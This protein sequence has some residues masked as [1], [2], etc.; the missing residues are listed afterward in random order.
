MKCPNSYCIYISYIGDSF[1]DCPFGEDEFQSNNIVGIAT[2]SYTLQ[3]TCIDQ[4]AYFVVSKSAYD[5]NNTF[6]CDQPCP[7][8]YICI[9]NRIKHRNKTEDTKYI[10]TSE[11]SIYNYSNLIFPW[12]VYFTMSPIL[13]IVYFTG[14]YC[15]IQNFD[16]SFHYWKFSEL[17]VLDLSYTELIN[18]KD[19]SLVKT[20]SKLKVLN[21]SHNQ[22]LTI[23]Q[24]FIFPTSL[25]IIDLS[26]TKT[27]SLKLNVFEN[28][29]FLKH[30]NLSNSLVST[31]QDMGI[32]EYFTLDSL[33]LEN[34]EMTNI[35]ENFFRGLTINSE[36]RASNYKLCCPQMLNP[37]ISVDKCHAPVDVISSCKHLVGD[38]L[39][40]IT[41]WTV[42]LITLVGNGIVLVYRIGWNREIFK[43]AYGLF[44]SGLAVSDFIMGVYLLL[45]A[46]VD[47]QYKNIYVLEDVKWRH[48]VLCQFAGF[49][50]TISSE[51]ST[52]FICLITTDRFLK[53]TF[54]FGQHKFTKVGKIYS[55]TLV[56]LIG[57]L[58]AI[59]PIIFTKWNI[60]SSNGLCLA[61]PLGSPENNG[62]IFSFIVFVVL[63][64]ILFLFIAIGQILIFVN[65]VNV[66]KSMQN[67]RNDA[68]R[69]QED[70]N[71]ARK[72]AFVALT[73]FMCWFPVG[74][75]G[76]L[77]LKGHIFDREVYAWIAVFVIPVN[78]ALNPII[79]TIP[80]IFHR[81]IECKI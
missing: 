67:M 69:R 22:N 25:K 35:K 53:I 27:S 5:S 18:S 1:R 9:S 37:N 61:L 75:L 23:D 31:F 32:P 38:I 43:K 46:V 29:T 54:P 11:Q 68:R 60:Y 58:L 8:N 33:N 4:L 39:K 52:F 47:I 30:L 81:N 12:N 76:F 20:F 63:N 70:L 50:S 13:Q 42:G 49:L 56:W 24:N 15:K 10:L 41:I 80:A 66:R 79:Y 59:I 51:T 21:I 65:I 40:R 44:V 62:W 45:I 3:E 28:V 55:L 19:M 17:I 57:F 2:V 71:I 6:L 48:S 36:L 14:S 26:Y 72:L 77:S 34:V 78:S 73:D 16:Y 74:I 64:F 7:K